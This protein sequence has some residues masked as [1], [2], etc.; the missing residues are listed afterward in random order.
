MWRR[1]ATVHAEASDLAAGRGGLH[2]AW[3]GGPSHSLDERL[4]V[5][6]GKHDSHEKG[7]RRKAAAWAGGQAAGGWRLKMA[8]A[9]KRHGLVT[10]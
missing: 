5:T 9:E 7:V 6:C 8:M 3:R 2:M 4:C 1:L 10:G